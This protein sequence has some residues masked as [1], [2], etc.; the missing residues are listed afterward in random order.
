MKLGSTIV[1]VEAPTGRIL[2]IAQNTQFS[3]DAAAAADPNKSALVFAGDQKYGSSGGFNAGSTFKLFTLID[4]LEKGHS[5][6]EV[7]NGSVRV[8]KRMTN[9]CDG[10]LGQHGGYARQQLRRRRRLHRHA[11]AVHRGVLEL[12]L[13]RDGRAARPLRHPEGR[14]QDGRHRCGGRLQRC[15]WTTQFSVI[16]SNRGVAAGDGRRLRDRRQQRRLLPAEGDRPGHS[17]RTATRSHPPQTTCTQVIDPKV[18]AT[19]AYALEGVMDSGGTG[20]RANPYDGTRSSARPERTRAYQT[21]IVESSSTGR[22]GGV[23]RQRRWQG[24]RLRALVRHPASRHAAQSA[25]Q[26]AADAFYGGDAFPAARLEPHQASSSRDLPERRRHDRRPG[27]GDPGAPRASTSIVGDAVDSRE[28]RASSPRRTPAP[29]RSRVARAVT[30]NPSNGQGIAV[31]DV[32]RQALDERDQRPARAPASA[33]SS[34]ARARRRHALRGPGQGDGH[35]PR[36]GHRREPQHGRS[37]SNY[38]PGRRRWH[39]GNVRRQPATAKTALTALGAVGAVGASAAVWGIG[40]ERYL[41]TVREHDGRASSPPGSAPIRVLHL[42]DAHMAPWQHRKQRWMAALAELQPDLIVNTG[43]NLGHQRR[44]ARPPRALSTRCAASPA[45]SCTGRTTTPLRRRATRC[46]T[47]PGRP[48]A[49][50]TPASRS[51][52]QALDGYLARRARLARPE[53]RGRLARGA[54]ECAST[55]SASAMRTA[56][57]TSSTCSPDSLE[58]LRARRRPATLDA[59]CHPCALPP[60]AR[61]VRRPRRRHDL[62]RPHPRRSG[63]RPGFGALVANCDIPLDQARGLSDVDARRPHGAAERERRHRALDLRPGALRMPAR[64]VAHRPLAPRRL[65]LDPP[66]QGRTAGASST[67]RAREPGAARH[68]RAR[69]RRIRSECDMP[70]TPPAP[71]PRPGA[72]P[73]CWRVLRRC[74][75]A[76]VIE[77]SDRRTHR[78]T[79]RRRAPDSARG[80]PSLPTGGTA[81]CSSAACTR[82]ASSPAHPRRPVRAPTT[83]VSGNGRRACPRSSSRAS[84]CSSRSTGRPPIR[85]RPRPSAGRSRRSRIATPDAAPLRVPGRLPRR[86]RSTG[87]SRLWRPPTTREVQE[88]RRRLLRRS[89]VHAAR[90]QRARRPRVR[91]PMPPT[92]G[93][94]ACASRRP[95]PQRGHGDPGRGAVFATGSPTLDRRRAGHRIRDRRR[96]RPAQDDRTRSAA[97]GGSGSA[98]VAA[99]RHFTTPAV[100]TPPAPPGASGSRWLGQDAAPRVRRSSRRHLDPGRGDLRERRWPFVDE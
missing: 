17:M 16:G 76:D 79:Q 91:R 84:T 61:R 73:G 94:H 50:P 62:R 90:H 55:R 29:A 14:Y 44:A 99:V 70:I 69:S 47:S 51:T 59:R 48:K 52:P 33:T 28:P 4:W 72:M 34:P 71:V 43:D 45:S 80:H 58:E 23:G 2:A 41:F 6:N 21:W 100:K 42:S 74:A 30:I 12:G 8:I 5:V 89:A 66:P 88:L 86:T 98:S 9:S 13:L 49:T 57:G 35:Q 67:H 46:S 11:D 38:T 19:A 85:C 75:R 27:Y 24:R 37:P 18:A 56:G 83:G 7:L 22:D 3:E 31:P 25:T 68:E 60:R 81:P 53:Q 54:P 26:A 36:S 93:R 20:S 39:G 64:G 78:R 87:R 95:R 82:T 63:A 96:H 1:S 65:S 92:R 10:R 97:P 40:I 32:S 15:R 77:C